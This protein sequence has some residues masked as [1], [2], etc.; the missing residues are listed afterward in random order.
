ML[1]LILGRAGTGKT[2]LIINEIR[3][4][5]GAH[6]GKNILIVPEQYSHEAERELLRACGDQCSLYAEV[7]SFSRLAHSVAREQGGAGRIY[8]DKGGRTLQMAL[9]LD[10]A[11]TSLTVYGAA[12]R[13]PEMISSLLSALDE[14]RYGC[15]EGE[16]LRTAAEH[17][18]G[19][20]GEKLR[21]LSLLR[22]TMAAVESESGLDPLSRLELLTEQIP[23][24][25]LLRDAHIYID[26]FADFTMQQQRIIRE[27]WLRGEVT[28]CLSCSDLHEQSEEFAI[29]ART[30][31]S[32]YRLAGED[33]L[34]TAILTVPSL[35][36]ESP[37][38]L[39]EERLFVYTPE[40]YSAGGAIT[41]R[42]AESVTAECELA[43]GEVLRL[44]RETGCRWREIAVAVRDFGSYESVLRSIF[45]RYGI[46]LYLSERSDLMQKPLPCLL[47][48]AYAVIGG[49]WRYED[50]F[51]YLRTGLTPLGR[52]DCDELENYVLLWDIR[53]GA[54]CSEQPWRQHPEGYNQKYDSD[55]QARLERLDALRRLAA[56]PLRKLQERSCAAHNA[57]AHC[58]A[59]AAFWEDLGLCARLEER[60]AELRSLGE[61]QSAQETL[62]LWELTVGALE[63]C[64]A[65]LG[66]TPMEADEF[67]RLFR[68]LLSQY[69]VGTIPVSVDRVIA[70]DFDRM[71]RRRLKHLLILGATDERIPFLSPAAGLFTGSERQQL[72]EL[73]IAVESEDEALDREFN[74]LYHVLTLP[75][76]SLYISRPLYTSSGAESR[77]SFL[78]E[79]V[80]KLFGLSEERGDLAAAR[81]SCRAGVFELAAA[82]NREA[83][84]ALETER[85]EDLARLRSAA[86]LSR[87]RL[88][89]ESVRALYSDETWLT[90]SRIDTFAACK[91]QYFLRYGL[92]AKVRQSAGFDPPALGTF[93]HY[94]LENVT[95][96]AAARGG[97]SALTDDEIRALTDRY[98]SDYVHT[99][100]EDFREK[101]PRFVY[102]F[103]RMRATV[104]KI[105]LDTAGEL[106]RSDFTPLDFE[107]NFSATPDLP[108]MKLGDGETALRLTGVADRIDG[109]EQDGK[110]M[111]RVVDYKTGHKEFS[112]SD[113][114]YGMGLQM[115]LYLF[116]LEKN[117]SRR[118]QKEIIPAGVLYVPARDVLLSADHRPTDAEILKEKAKTLR[119]SGLVLDDGAV[120][121]AMEHGE[122]GFLYLPI[123]L[124]R[125][126]ERTSDSLASAE[127]LGRLSRHLE[128]L[129]TDMAGELRRGS[130]Q[131]D[132]LYRG[133]NE[134][135]CLLCS[136][137]DACHFDESK[138]QPR[139]KLKLRAPEFWARLE[140]QERSE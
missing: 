80:Q 60:A 19:A 45:T 116:A 31:R 44:V 107:L 62:Q 25:E 87:G 49:G 2:G 114:W 104:E 14:L 18:E 65:V 98:V 123:K 38:R 12:K 5:V 26:G 100:L 131:A 21:D 1:R 47:T 133:E 67:I 9:A 29:T 132:P 69:D 89:A 106:R 10:R 94:I 3:E 130:I 138:D 36:E 58:E 108:P 81:S 112:L 56:L 7:L 15:V 117:G 124:N 30:A 77:A 93:M 90:A 85:A 103:R 118:Y 11:S 101:S 13:Q 111:L 50:M 28:V 55:T 40:Q 63:Q 105:V 20:L 53:G 64:A 42:S 96:E 37:L 70:G 27:L 8:A 6:Q 66:E 72:Q 16:Q 95:K 41:L 59:M 125:A 91:F 54:W 110:L 35:Q 134:N 119:R 99:E 76:E 78:T 52:S 135:Q 71:R 140:K 137:Y 122:D 61:E 75:S 51:S 127:Q 57:R 109:W 32:L 74:L 128:T 83:A 73:D 24:S 113:V 23:Q 4:R 86:E 82:G 84:E 46:P 129:L 115:L 92:K 139:Y 33:G 48:A 136:Y 68:L 34:K 102:L 120:I 79:R 39:L 121:N 97:F 126:G 43:A 17:C 22:D 88:R